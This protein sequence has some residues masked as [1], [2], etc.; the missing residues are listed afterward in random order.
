MGSFEL[1][2]E[3]RDTIKKPKVEKPPILNNGKVL[4]IYEENKAKEY[5][6]NR[7]ESIIQELKLTEEDIEEIIEEIIKNWNIER[8]IE[9]IKNNE[10]ILSKEDIIKIIEKETANEAEE[11]ANKVKKE[12]KETEEIDKK[13]VGVI[14]KWLNWKNSSHYSDIIKLSENWEIDQ[15]L[16]L[17][18]WK[19]N[20][21]FNAIAIDLKTESPE[22]YNNFKAS[23]I[24]IDSS[25]RDSFD[26]FESKKLEAQNILK[27]GTPIV[28]FDWKKW[29]T[30]DGKYNI[31]LDEKWDRKLSLWNS[32][33]KIKSIL[34]NED[35]LR[36]NDEID[37]TLANNLK[38]IN[39]TLNTISS[40]LEY[41]DKAILNKIELKDIK[42]NIKNTN[43]VLY[44]E[45]NIENL[46]SPNDIK[47]AFI[48]LQKKKE[49]EKEKLI[50][51][52][53]EEKAK[54]ISEN[55]RLAEQKDKIKKGMLNFLHSIWFDLINQDI[56]NAI[57][58]YVNSN[59][60]S[61]KDFPWLKWDIDLEKWKLWFDYDNW[62]NNSL[63]PKEMSNFIRLFNK[64]LT[65]NINEPNIINWD[66][67]KVS[68]FD[69]N[70]ITRILN[71]FSIWTKESEMI[72]NLKK[73]N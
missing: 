7:L 63:H 68:Y 41:L 57:I 37:K 2:W 62:N 55:T 72:K 27:I 32:D 70:K 15:V 18:K 47:N 24:A 40:I 20:K 64:M 33:Y 14:L 48:W 59:K 49:E 11:I 56:T 53:K 4:S 39:E 10:Y 50:E 61:L 22:K 51:N 69:P 30:I 12:A 31:E 28:S 25:F 1:L 52:A 13:Y 19:D 67:G 17:L 71:N 46:N 66:S 65:G 34:E 5:I 45:L 73:I 38:P 43:I 36:K 6:E 23:L 21:S 26:D 8:I 29:K 54:I 58:E 44:N 60:S 9:N 42:E 16:K 3:S 35:N